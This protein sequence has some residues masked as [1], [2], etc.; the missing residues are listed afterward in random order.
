MNRF[1]SALAALLVAALAVSLAPSRAI[2]HCEV[3]CGIYDDPARIAQLREDAATIEKA[4]TG[5]NDLAA[6]TD[7]LSANQLARWV[8][9][10]DNHAS[11]IEETI[12]V[13]FMAQRVKPVEPGTADYDAYLKK[14][15]DHHKVMV[16]AMKTKQNVDLKF[17]AD[18]RAAI[19]VIAAYYPPA[20]SPKK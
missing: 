3:P 5:I 19:D 18:L 16:A 8:D 12:A 2:A 17:V 15:A 7:A 20:E 9:A 14:L 4:M 6:K 10:K 11:M 13:Y 1:S